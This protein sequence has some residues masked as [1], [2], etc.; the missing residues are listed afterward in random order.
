MDADLKQI[1]ANEMA[2]ALSHYANDRAPSG[3]RYWRIDVSGE[4]VNGDG[5]WSRG[6]GWFIEY[7]ADGTC[8]LGWIP[9]W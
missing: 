1:V 6:V 5:G 9:L 2:N 4:A 8:G 3:A 7:C